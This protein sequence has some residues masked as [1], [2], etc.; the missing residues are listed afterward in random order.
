LR[1]ITGETLFSEVFFD[2]VFVPD[3]D[4]VGEPGGGWAIARA[5]LANERVGIGSGA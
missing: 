1:E 2:D 5:T 4:V 3:S